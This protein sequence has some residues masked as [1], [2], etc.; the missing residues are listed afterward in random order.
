MKYRHVYFSFLFIFS[1]C[2]KK[3]SQPVEIVNKN[4]Q[5]IQK[6]ITNASKQS[7]N[8]CPDNGHCSIKI[9][10]NKALYVNDKGS[11]LDYE[12]VDDESKTVIRYEFSKNKDKKK[13]DGDYTEEIVFE[14]NNN[15]N[16]AEFNDDELSKTKILYGR[17][18]FCRGSS[19]LFKVNTGK[20]IL[21]KEND[22]ISF[23]LSYKTGKIPQIISYI[24]VK[25][26]ILFFD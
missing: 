8:L 15:T 26:N 24:S 16:N 5:I 10:K 12:F 11:D 20:L 14:I 1:F 18:C 23:E 4:Q 6:E 2:S 17:H 22:N 7:T 9:I 3:I 25:N 19:G 21:K 13:Y